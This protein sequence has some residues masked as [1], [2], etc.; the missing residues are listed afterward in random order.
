MSFV[1]GL[2]IGI[3]AGA[4]FAFCAMFLLAIILNQAHIC[5]LTGG[6]QVWK[7]ILRQGSV[8]AVLFLGCFLPAEADA[9]AVR[10][11]VRPALVGAVSVSGVGKSA[12]GSHPIFAAIKSIELSSS[13][14]P[15]DVTIF[16]NPE[17]V[18]GHCAFLQ[19]SEL[20]IRQFSVEDS[21]HSK[22]TAG[23]ENA[24]ACGYITI[25]HIWGVSRRELDESNRAFLPYVIG[26]CLP[27]IG[28]NNVDRWLL[29]RLNIKTDNLFDDDVGSQLAASGIPSN[30]SLPKTEASERKSRENE[31]PSKLGQALGVFRNQTIKYVFVIG[32]MLCV[33]G[34]FILIERGRVIL[35]GAMGLVGF[36]IAL[37]SGIATLG[38]SIANQIPW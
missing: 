11:E 30:H 20:F 12:I 9:T 36:A 10:G 23:A 18:D 25:S 32:G 34:G 35:G 14:A 7:T 3:A 33:F 13:L 1:L 37:H 17:D 31:P 21:A 29:T 26:G 8:A 22:L 24:D 2:L 27:A 16:N 6:I 19:V 15:E 28:Y 4:V 5:Y 38:T